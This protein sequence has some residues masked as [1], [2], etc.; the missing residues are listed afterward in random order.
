MIKQALDPEQH[1]EGFVLRA[2]GLP[3]AAAQQAA[4]DAADAG[5]SGTAGDEDD[6]IIV[7]G[8]AA[9]QQPGVAA[10]KGKRRLDELPEEGG[11]GKRARINGVLSQAA[12]DGVIELN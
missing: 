8:C 1:P 11:G 9:K 4:A 5:P 12:T 6:G 7:T 10:G 3:S 2:D